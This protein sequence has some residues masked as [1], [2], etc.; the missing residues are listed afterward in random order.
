[1]PREEVIRSDIAKLVIKW[2]RVHISKLQQSERENLL[3]LVDDEL[4]KHV[5]GQDPGIKSIA[6]AI[7]HSR[8]GFSN[9]VRPI[10]SFMFVVVLTKLS[11]LKL[12]HLTFST[13]KMLWRG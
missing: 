11:W 9:L 6:K 5:V 13:L 10:A 8:A 4:H 12:W 2:T 7:H 1:M 3:H